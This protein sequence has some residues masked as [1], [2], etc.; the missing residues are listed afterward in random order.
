M[1]SLQKNDYFLFDFYTKVQEKT[2]NRIYVWIGGYLLDL[3]RN[4]LKH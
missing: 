1:L 2:E 4:A 3:I